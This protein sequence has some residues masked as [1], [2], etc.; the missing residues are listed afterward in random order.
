[1]PRRRPALRHDRIID[2]AVRVAD[3][4]GLA[5][6]SM[7]NVGKELNV[8]AMSLYHHLAG[9]DALL[10]GLADWFFTQIAL[11]RPDQPWRP[12]MTDRAASAR[13]ALSKHPWAL[14]LVESRRSPGP[15]LLR[16][17]ER[18]LGCLRQHGFPI[19]LAAHAFS[20]IDSYVYGFVLTELNLPFSPGEG[21]EDFVDQLA[22]QLPLA[23][24]PHLVELITEQVRGRE[25]SYA[26]EFEFGLNLILDSL[27]AHLEPAD[28]GVWGRN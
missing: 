8:E 12:A 6:V 14:G 27:E 26:D 24:Y 2:A 23:D 19:P 18:V 20:A 10:D 15:A 9:K 21:A 7:R 5:Q 3:R 1:M 28:H 13:A 17:H 11:P 16:H 22:E 25:Y 4:G